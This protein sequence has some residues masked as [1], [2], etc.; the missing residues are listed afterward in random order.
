MNYSS[1]LD[2]ALIQMKYFINQLDGGR[3]GCGKFRGARDVIGH[4]EQAEAGANGE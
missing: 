3:P 4:M 1:C 2:K